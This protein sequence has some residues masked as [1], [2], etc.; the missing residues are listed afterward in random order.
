MKLA[1]IY[2]NT[3]MYADFYIEESSF[4]RMNTRV[5]TDGIAGSDSI[6]MRFDEPLGHEYRGRL[7]YLSPDV[8]TGTGT[9]HLRAVVDNPYGELR[10]GMYATISLPED[11]DSHAL[12]VRDASIATDQLGKYVYIEATNPGGGSNQGQTRGVWRRPGGGGGTEA[13]PAAVV[14]PNHPFRGGGGGGVKPVIS[15]K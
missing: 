5:G 10:S 2:D 14:A 11:I 1:T 15:D 3:R 6:P 7:D 12:L 8:N 4:M 9:M 13:H